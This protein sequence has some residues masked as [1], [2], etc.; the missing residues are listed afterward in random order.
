MIPAFLELAKSLQM[1]GYFPNLAS[2]LTK[3]AKHTSS[4]RKWPVQKKL[5]PQFACT[6]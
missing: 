3:I 4:V 2:P 6:Y 1:Y 5:I